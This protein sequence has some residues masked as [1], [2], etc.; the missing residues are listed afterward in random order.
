M[1]LL[2]DTNEIR[3]K[4]KEVLNFLQ[5]LEKHNPRN[6]SDIIENIKNLKEMRIDAI[7]Q[8]YSTI[9]D[10]FNKWSKGSIIGDVVESLIRFEWGLFLF[11]KGTYRDHVLH[12]LNVYLLGQFI[13]EK[14]NLNVFNYQDR[15][16]TE[17]TW[18]VA[19]L[20]HD[21]GY[22]YEKLSEAV[23]DAFGGVI[24]PISTLGEAPKIDINSPIMDRY[25]RLIA[26]TYETMFEKPQKQKEALTNLRKEKNLNLDLGSSW[27]FYRE[28]REIL[29]QNKRG[30]HGPVSALITLDN[31]ISKNPYAKNN[32]WFREWYPYV[33]VAA[34]SMAL[35]SLPTKILDRFKINEINNPIPALLILCDEIQDFGRPGTKSSSLNLKG[36][37]PEQ[38]NKGITIVLESKT[39]EKIKNLKNKVD[40][41]SNR[42]LRI[43]IDKEILNDKIFYIVIRVKSPINS[44]QTLPT[45]KHDI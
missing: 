4:I 26:K 1:R 41:I 16:K 42:I 8:L 22:V 29:Q 35:H 34:T 14:L 39:K 7:N 38:Q 3:E 40:Q 24:Q 25:L 20:L 18:A 31:L 36:I 45:T 11:H 44:I 32:Y 43:N 23:R 6:I 28:L 37:K 17:F 5:H 12:M 2:V 9:I 10:H 33:L 30:V 27:N 15:N 13:V 21:V 19:S